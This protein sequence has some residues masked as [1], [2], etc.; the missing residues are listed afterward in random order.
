MAAAPK[1]KKAVADEAAVVEKIASWPKPYNTIGK[2]L[3]KIVLDTDPELSPR[4][5]Y[6]SAGYA[7]GSGPVLCFFRLDE[8]LSFGLTEK[9]N[10]SVDDG[11]TDLLIGSAWFL[12]K[13]DEP[14]EA[15]IAEIVRKAVS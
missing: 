14:T 13:L 1:S 9:A 10:I 11:A 4:L 2:R 7:R 8:Y 12:T 15:R 3:H 6:G 5:W